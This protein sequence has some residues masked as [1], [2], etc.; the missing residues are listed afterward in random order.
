MATNTAEF[1][2]FNGE[3]KPWADAN[4]HVLSHSLHYGSSVF[5][6]IRCYDTPKGS[7]VFRHK[8]HMQRLK[9][10]AKIYRFP[11]N[12]TVEELM[13][14][15]R[16]TLIANKLKSAYIRPLGFIGNVGLG[17]CPPEGYNF[18]LA[19]AAFEWG[20]YLGEDALAKGV[21]AMVSSWTR[22]APNTIPTMAKAGGNYL[23]S[24]LIGTEARRQGFSEGISLDVNGHVAEC[25]GENIFVVK[26][27]VLYTP[28]STD[29]ILLG[30]TRDSI[31]K[32]AQDL[33]YEVR[34]ESMSREFLYLGDEVFMSGTAAEITPVSSIDRIQIGTGC[35]G[36]VTEQLQ[37]RFFG[38]FDGTTEDKYGWLDPVNQ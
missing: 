18:D 2:W 3:L 12:Y 13:Q 37:K 16:E 15:C 7:M 24:L 29:S 20:A 4:V 5:E 35:R 30:I 11:L 19:I 34:E 25:S 9:D 22:M 6:G 8:E 14:A 26:D 23:S 33:G 1:I 28:K 38:L 32:L 36:P 27:G 21:D 31:M 10:S 17:V